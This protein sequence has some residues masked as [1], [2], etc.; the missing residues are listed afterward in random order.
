MFLTVKRNAAIM[1]AI[2][3]SSLPVHVYNMT[4]WASL[5]TCQ[6]SISGIEPGHVYYIIQYG[7]VSRPISSPS[8]A[9]SLGI[10]HAPV[11]SGFNWPKLEAHVSSHITH[12]QSPINIPSWSQAKCVGFIPYRQCANSTVVPDPRSISGGNN[13]RCSC[14]IHMGN[15]PWH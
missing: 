4:I 10:S 7:P 5:K 8:A 6:S 9:M 14:A 11:C 1:H 12:F 2:M 15:V 3:Q 13:P